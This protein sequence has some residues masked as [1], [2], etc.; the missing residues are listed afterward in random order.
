L[1]SGSLYL[2]IYKSVTELHKRNFINPSSQG[3]GPRVIL[4]P[5]FLG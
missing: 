1:F 3:P 4:R 5:R 2:S